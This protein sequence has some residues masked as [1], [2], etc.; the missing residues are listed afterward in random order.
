MGVRGTVARVRRRRFL[1]RQPGG[2][3]AQPAGGD[4]DAM[5]RRCLGR[6]DSRPHYIWGVLAA[7]RNAATLGIRRVSALEFGVAGGNGL[8]ALENAAL[9]TAQLTGVEVE[10][11]GFDTGTGMP[12]AK[13]HRD[14]PWLIREGMFPMDE[15][16]LRERLRH[17]QL[18]L[19]PVR[20]TVATWAGEGHPPLGFAA[21]D[22]DYYSSTMEAFALFDG[23]AE[24]ALPRVVCYFDDVFGYGWSDFAGERAAIDD[25]NRSHD[26]RKIGKIHGL[27]YGL[28]EPERDAPWPEQVYLAHLFDHP[29]YCSPEG[30]FEGPQAEV[31]LAAH[32]LPTDGRGG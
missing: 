31:W 25:F 26:Q 32:R 27:R 5:F 10:V 6:T 2:A 8:I 15:A 19:G 24:L 4:L 7:A 1:G 22:L 30:V 17:A 23:D 18:V 29:R 20:E 28:P 21:F 14:V 16:A 3:G 9:A 12:P 11:Y 13:D